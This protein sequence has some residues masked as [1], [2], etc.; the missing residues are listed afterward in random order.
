MD[1]CFYSDSFDASTP[2]PQRQGSL[3]ISRKTSWGTPIPPPSS[4]KDTI[5]V[6]CMEKFDDVALSSKADSE[7]DH[8]LDL[9]HDDTLDTIAAIGLSFAGEEDEQ[10]TGVRRERFSLDDDGPQASH[11]K[12]DKP[13]DKW[14]KQIQRKATDRRQTVGGDYN[15]HVDNSGFLESPGTRRQFPS[16]KKSSSGSSFGFV[17]AVKTAS[18]SLASFSV[19]PRS[20]RTELSSRQQ[21]TDLSSKASNRG[22]WSEDSSYISRGLIIDQAVTNRSLQRRRILEELISTEESYLADAKFLMT[23]SKLLKLLSII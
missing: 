9:D 20:R 15:H 6:S 19:A 2:Q 3:H 13:F 1:S 16:H 10:E 22:R 7:S 11:F 12:Q 17:T 4:L 5:D 8:E 18:I 23:V 14:M 21:R